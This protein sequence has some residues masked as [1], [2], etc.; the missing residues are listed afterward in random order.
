[1]IFWRHHLI[2]VLTEI[3]VM[4]TP[5]SDGLSSC[6]SHQ[7]RVHNLFDVV[8]PQVPEPL[9]QDALFVQVKILR[10]KVKVRAERVVQRWRFPVVLAQIVMRDLLPERSQTV[11]PRSELEKHLGIGC[12]A[13]CAGGVPQ[14]QRDQD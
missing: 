7:R 13:V 9:T 3:F 11:E 14:R 5:W 12:S 8:L 1:M 2:N 4:K 10:N 6:L